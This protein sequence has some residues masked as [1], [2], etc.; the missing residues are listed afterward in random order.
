MAEKKKFKITVQEIVIIVA[1][2]LLAAG[3]IIYSVFRSRLSSAVDENVEKINSAFEENSSFKSA[4]SA[5]NSEHLLPDEDG[6]YYV[7]FKD[8]NATE[9]V[10]Y[11]DMNF[12]SGYVYG[13][14]SCCIT[15]YSNGYYGQIVGYSSALSYDILA[16]NVVFSTGTFSPQSENIELDFAKSYLA[17]KYAGCA[18]ISG[19]KALC[20]KDGALTDDEAAY[21]KSKLYVI[22]SLSSITAESKGS[23]EEKEV[24]S[25]LSSFTSLT[26]ATVYDSG[27]YIVEDGCVFTANRSVLKYVFPFAEKVVCPDSVFSIA[28]GALINAKSVTELTI[29][30]E[31]E[32]IYSLMGGYA[33][34]V[35]EITF[36]SCVLSAENLFF[37][38]ENLESITLSSGFTRIEEGFFSGAS[39]KEIFFG[40]DT[41][42][43][44]FDLPQGCR[45]SVPFGCELSG[46]ISSADYK[47]TQI[48]GAPYKIFGGDIA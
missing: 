34:G 25:L 30:C 14:N 43:V 21:T 32:N 8:K 33:K 23:D 17:E 1:V 36:T 18:F 12:V 19:G 22:D 42:Y 20:V 13:E 16:I 11:A 7:W 15:V 4:V 37:G 27:N 38:C 6:Y 39:P 40:A 41:K 31:G 28:S 47:A 10:A 26:S 48:N 46:S 5:L 44:Y 2:L 35:K 29:P 3:F 45:V 24:V 9:T